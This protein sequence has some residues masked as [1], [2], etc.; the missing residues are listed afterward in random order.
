MA[1]ASINF[2]VATGNSEAHM[3]RLSSVSYLLENETSTNEFKKYIIV[4][5][6]L[7]EAKIITKEKTKRAMQKLAIENF[8]QEAVLNIKKETSIKDV[9]KLFKK[10]NKEFNGG[11]EVFSIALHK[12]EGV[13][14]DSKYEIKDLTWDSKNVKWFL[15]DEEVTNEVFSIAPG[16]DVFFNSEDKKWYKEKSFKNKVDISKYQKFYN[17]HSHILFTKFDKSKGKNVRLSKS[18]YSKIQD[19]TAEELNME[20]G[21][22]WSKN[23]R[24]TH[25]QRKDLSSKTD[26]LKRDTLEDLATINDLKKEMRD[27]RASFKDNGAVRSNYAELEQ[28]NKELLV[29]LKEEE[30]TIISMKHQLSNVEETILVKNEL[31]NSLKEER[32]LT[33]KVAG[34]YIENYNYSD[35]EYTTLGKELSEAHKTILE[36]DTNISTLKEENEH[37]K[38]GRFRTK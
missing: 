37:S 16:R 34:D 17:Y 15:E 4:N 32:E 20:R 14:I 9:E 13:F 28:L 35:E 30:L 38:Y 12:D 1:K 27:L 5:D 11:F 7:E 2:Q 19:L 24:M 8:T 29:Q 23:K 6:F 31:I 36:Q 25:W 26:E 3:F 10:F 33:E 18:D 22:K 21:D